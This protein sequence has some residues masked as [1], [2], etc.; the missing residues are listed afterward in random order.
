[1]VNGHTADVV[2]QITPGGEAKR[3]KGGKGRSD[4]PGGD[5]GSQ[6]WL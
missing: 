5:V 2:E 3:I 6:L 1:M 4:C